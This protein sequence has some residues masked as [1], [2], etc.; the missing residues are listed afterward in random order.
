MAQVAE[1]DVVIIGSG[2]GGAPIAHTLV[3]AGKS[4]LVIEKGPLFRPQADDPLGLSD[5]KRDELISD[6][7]EKILTVPGLANTGASFF[8]SHVEPDLNDEPHIYRNGSN[9]DYAT[10][11]GYTCQC[12]GGGT[13]HYGGVSLRFTPLDFQLASFNKGR[14][15]LAPDVTADVLAEM[16]DWPFGYDALEP[17]YCKAEELVGING[18][19]AN[20]MKPASQDH[21]QTPLPPNPISK[22]A[23]DGMVALNMAPYRTPQA[24]ITQDHAPSGRKVGTIG[25]GSDDGPQTGYVNR[26]GDALDYKSSTWVALL[27]PISREPN[28][29]LWPNTVVTHLEAQGARITRLHLRDPSGRNL[30]VSGK[31]VV[32]ACSAIESVRLLLLSGE[33]D[34]A[35][36]GRINGNGLLGKYFLTHCFGGASAVM[37]GRHDKSITIDSDWAT[38]FCGSEEFI[39]ENGLWAGGA[40]YNNTSDQALP[41]S[42]G[43]THGAS[44][45]DT[46]WHAFNNDTQVVGDRFV[47]F[48]NAQFGRRLSV[49]FMANQ[50]PQRENRIE[51]HDRVRDKWGR[52]VAYIVKSWHPH[53]QRLM[54]T[55]ASKCRDILAYGGDGGGGNYPVDGFGGVFMSENSLARIA[56]HILGGARFGSDPRDSVLDPNCRAWSFDNLYVADGAFMPTSGG[57]NPT[58]TIQANAFRVGDQIA[59]SGLV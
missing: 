40:I 29:T 57:A 39:R 27:R 32:V 33:N 30:T 25:P 34:A 17:W 2:G 21:Y 9:G 48:L 1:F 22:Y 37:P 50:L 26:Y 38:D 43:R 54:L 7:P 35:F 4:V 55:L 41:I 23:H 58:L 52:R 14:T 3:K 19:R 49:S 18:Q 15:D 5:Y 10:I 31:V 56:N 13:Q 44:D 47:E 11:E 45:L 8:T 46:L 36:A 24:V 59:S 28:F 42:L 12:V 53:D 6:G 51:L 20:Q 16:R